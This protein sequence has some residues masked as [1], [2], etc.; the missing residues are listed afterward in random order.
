MR[1]VA[2]RR[3]SE[4]ERTS[5]SIAVSIAAADSPEVCRYGIIGGTLEAVDELLKKLAAPGVELRF[6]YEPV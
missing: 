5:P 4:R 1:A 3:P 6:V 2:G